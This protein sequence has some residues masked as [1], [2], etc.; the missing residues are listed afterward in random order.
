MPKK[1][2]SNPK[3]EKMKIAIMS[4]TPKKSGKKCSAKKQVSE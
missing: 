3:I 2:K 4:G 1:V